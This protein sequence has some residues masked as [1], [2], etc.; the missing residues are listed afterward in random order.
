[1]R[2]PP[3][4]QEGPGSQGAHSA[5]PGA[6]CAGAPWGMRGLYQTVMGPCG[7]SISPVAL[8]CNLN[9]TEETRGLAAQEDG[10]EWR[11][12]GGGGVARGAKKGVRF[13]KRFIIDRLNEHGEGARA[14]EHPPRA[15]LHT[16]RRKRGK[17][18]GPRGRRLPLAISCPR[19]G[20]RSVYHYMGA[21]LFC[22]TEE[23]GGAGR[24][25]VLSHAAG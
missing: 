21:R 19:E 23:S 11:T 22:T 9:R 2:A 6:C 16:A 17:R 12:G 7:G 5:E 20:R 25:V 8:I 4:A 3:L 10:E 18:L 13:L 14:G 15:G 24:G 1:M